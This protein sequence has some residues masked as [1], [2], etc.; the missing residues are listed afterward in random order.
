[1]AGFSFSAGCSNNMLAARERGMVNASTWGRR[2]GVSAAAVVE[3]MRPG[4]AHHTGTGR[5]GRSRLTPVLPDDLEPTGEQLAA[6]R[7]FDAAA[8]A[9]KAA[10]P[11]VERA[12][13][14]RYLRWPKSPRARRVPAEVVQPLAEIRLFADGRM[15][16]VEADG[17]VTTHWERLGGLVVA[18]DGQVVVTANLNSVY[19]DAETI[20][21]RIAPR[22]DSA[23]P[24]GGLVAARAARS[25]TLPAAPGR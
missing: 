4:E 11:R 10:P 23:G 15:E 6:M 9:A 14:A 13:V 7:A 18:R 22:V 17:R 8:R 5:R 16:A 21:A 12:C 24:A 20:A 25:I 2:H 3:V 19:D 1:M